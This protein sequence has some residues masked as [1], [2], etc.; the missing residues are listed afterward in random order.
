MIVE[1][2]KWKRIEATIA[3]ALAPYPE[4]AAAVAKALEELE[5]A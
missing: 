5:A 4:A 1:S 2:P 3:K